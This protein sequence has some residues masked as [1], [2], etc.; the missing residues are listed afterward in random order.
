MAQYAVDIDAPADLVYRLIAE[1]PLRTKW[2][3]ELEST[4][5]PDRELQTGDRFDGCSALLGHRFIGASS[6]VDAQ[7]GE[8]LEEVV[9]IGARFHTT[10][11]VVTRDTTTPSCRVQHTFDI[12]FPAGVLGRLERWLL[13]WRLDRLQR[14]AMHRL[15]DTATASE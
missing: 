10:W 5:A 11:E 9:V 7:H 6:V 1:V 2:L 15:R 14:I 13:G 8:R 3:P 4:N 12:E